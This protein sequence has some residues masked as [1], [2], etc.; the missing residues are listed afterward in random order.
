MM[1]ETVVTV[2]HT[3][4]RNV[5]HQ[6]GTKPEGALSWLRFN[7]D[8]FKTTPGI[9]KLLQLFF[10]IICMSCASPALTSATHWFLFVA[11]TSFIATLIWVFV[12]LLGIREVLQLPI[13]WL[14]TELVNTGIITVLYTIAF[15]VQLAKWSGLA[16]SFVASNITAGVFGI[17]N[18]L[19]YAAGVYFLHLEWKSSGGAS[20]N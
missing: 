15:I 2:E 1:T 9:L 13:N 11:V 7:I 10:G 4:T 18:A 5:T 16:G 20:T 3:T 6:A 17:F 12:Y 14:L 19:A 8:Y